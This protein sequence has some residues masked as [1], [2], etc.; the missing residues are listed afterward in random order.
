M[1]Q[2]ADMQITKLEAARRQ[3]DAAIGLYFN[4]GDAIAIHTLVGAAHIL[5]TDLSK[6]AEQE[7][8]FQ[9]YIRPEK[10]AEVERAIR[11]PQNFFKHADKGTHEDILEFDPHG[12]ELMLFIEVETYR[13]LVGSVTDPMTVLLTYAAGTWGQEAFAAA[14]EETVG[15]IS[16]LAEQMSKRDFFALSLD[17]ARRRSL[18]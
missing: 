18:P 13:G 17:A 4:D 6:A 7:S 2:S 14:P 15:E 10:R 5:L 3:L 9:R 1:L 11:R 16:A 12:T 8:L